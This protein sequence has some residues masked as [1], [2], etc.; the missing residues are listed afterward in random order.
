MHTIIIQCI[1]KI[2]TISRF[3]LICIATR[4]M[5]SASWGEPE[6]LNYYS[7]V[8]VHCFLC[9]G[10]MEPCSQQHNFVCADNVPLI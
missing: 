10:R 5:L 6:Y 3:A 1:N 9:T 4:Q 2:F 8:C 7:S